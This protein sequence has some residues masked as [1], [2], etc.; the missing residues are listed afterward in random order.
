VKRLVVM[1]HA[2]SDWDAGAETDHARPLNARGRDEA[3]LVAKKLAVRGFTPDLVTSSD[4]VRTTETLELAKA[5]WPGVRVA[6]TGTFYHAG[7]HAVRAAAADVPG[8]V[9]TW[10]VLGHNPGWEEMTSALAGTDVELKTSYAAVLESS[11]PTFADALAGDMK[12]VALVK[13]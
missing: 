9:E 13:P 4:S 11:A 6:M 2:K 1:R 10:L 7:I 5:A 3:P 12:L 8:D